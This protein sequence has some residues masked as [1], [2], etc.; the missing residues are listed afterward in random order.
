MKKL[1]ENGLIVGRFQSFHKGH[2][3]LIRQALKLCKRVYIYIGSAQ[4]EGTKIN[5]FSFLIR[6]EMISKVFKKELRF[7]R[8]FIKPLNDIGK[9]NSIEWGRYVLN[10]IKDD[11]DI[12]IDLYVTGCEKER[13]SWFTNDIAPKMDELRITRRNIIIS[14]TDCRQ[15]LLENNFKK[16][17]TMVSKKLYS[18]Y[19]VLNKKIKEVY[20]NE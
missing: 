6:K 11:Y 18:F 5:P 1:Y 7:R 3:F 14:G 13:S 17:S 10:I 8:V 2:E 9:G 4:E 15:A 12:D 19:S 20:L 16:W